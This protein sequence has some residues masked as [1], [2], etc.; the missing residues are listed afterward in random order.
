M[1]RG[2][3]AALAMLV[4]TLVVSCRDIP[5]PESGI[6]SISPL[7]LPS[8]AI[9]VGDTMRDSLGAVAPLR[10]VAYGVD[11]DSVTPQPTPTFVVLDT[12]A[13]LTIHEGVSVDLLR[14]VLAALR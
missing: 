1:R 7:M 3:A 14:T 5:A 4:A 12:G 10:V 2:H 6:F 8:P 9:V 11:G 13:R